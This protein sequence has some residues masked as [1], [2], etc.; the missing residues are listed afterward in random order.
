M[1][2]LKIEVEETKT[3]WERIKPIFL[4][5]FILLTIYCLFLYLFIGNHSSHMVLPVMMIYIPFLI[6]IIFQSDFYC[7]S[8]IHFIEITENRVRIT[9]T[10]RNKK[11]ETSDSI[12]KFIFRFSSGT[13]IIYFS[14]IKIT[15]Q[16]NVIRQSD[17]WGWRKEKAFDTLLNYLE[18]RHLL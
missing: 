8:Y 15:F 2:N 14:S 6:M 16:G 17:K 12:E 7:A 11:F 3:Y 9:G 10:K 13:R 5:R 1:E 4:L 18:K